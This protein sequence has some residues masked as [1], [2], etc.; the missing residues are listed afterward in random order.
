[1]QWLSEA[2]PRRVVAIGMNTGDE[3]QLPALHRPFA[4]LVI[5]FDPTV[6]QD[7]AEQLEQEL[8]AQGAHVATDA[9]GPAADLWDEGILEAVPSRRSAASAIADYFSYQVSGYGMDVT[10]F[11]ILSLDGDDADWREVVD[12]G[13]LALQA[14]VDWRLH[15]AAGNGNLSQVLQAIADGWPLE[16]LDSDLHETPLHRAVVEQQLSIV[17]ALIAAGVNVDRHCEESNETPL[18]RVAENGSIEMLRTLLEAGANPT[19][20]G[21]FGSALEVAARRKTARGRQVHEI[22][23]EHVDRSGFAE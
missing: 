19:I 10:D 11:V 8:V 13:K 18:A 14:N 1:M 21:C 5:A 20:V 22:L 7:R 6:P 17:R 16:E 23:R 4:V 15:T 12:A 3:L 9:G 2:K